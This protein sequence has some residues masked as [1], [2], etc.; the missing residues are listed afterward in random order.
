MVVF[1]QYQKVIIKFT[2][3]LTVLGD[4]GKQLNSGDLSVRCIKVVVLYLEEQSS[5]SLAGLGFGTRN[6]FG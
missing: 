5:Q 2:E 4:L 6:S 3:S 1:I